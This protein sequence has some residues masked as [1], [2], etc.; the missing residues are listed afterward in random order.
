MERSEEVN[1]VEIPELAEVPVELQ[2]DTELTESAESSVIS[3]EYAFPLLANSNLLRKFL[4]MML[5][6]SD[7]GKQDEFYGNE[8][9]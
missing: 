8:K 3:D 7:S 5:K 1:P 6:I 4:E 2:D 9:F